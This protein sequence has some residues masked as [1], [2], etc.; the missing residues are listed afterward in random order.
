MKVVRVLHKQK[1]TGSGW[2]LQRGAVQLGKLRCA[3]GAVRSTAS[4]QA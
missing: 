4:Q 2:P 1:A 3:G